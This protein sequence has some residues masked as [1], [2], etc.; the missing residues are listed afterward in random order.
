VSRPENEGFELVEHTADLALRGRAPALPGLFRVM[1]QAL[2]SVIVDPETVNPRLERRVSLRG[3]STEDLLHDWLEEL[4]ALH[5]IHGEVYGEFEPRI[6]KNVL[7]ATVRGEAIDPD[8]HRLGIE[9]KAVTW[10]DLRL[11]ETDSGCEATVLLDI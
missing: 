6:A 2:F 10:H 1:A 8:R 4:N 3:D 7:E 9:V 5:Q 11:T